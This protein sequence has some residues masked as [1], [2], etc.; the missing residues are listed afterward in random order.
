M[1]IFSFNAYADGGEDKML[2]CWF[3]NKNSGISAV[4]FEQYNDLCGSQL[5]LPVGYQGWPF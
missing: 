2:N 4:K 3:D 1:T 5:N